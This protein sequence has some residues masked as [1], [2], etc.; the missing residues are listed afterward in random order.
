MLFPE[1]LHLFSQ[2]IRIRSGEILQTMDPELLEHLPSFGTDAAHLTQVSLRSSLGIAES[3]P[4]AEC[5]LAT[6]RRKG[7]WIVAIEIKTEFAQG[8]SQLLTQTSGHADT[9]SRRT[10]TPSTTTNHQRIPHRS[11]LLLLQQQRHQGKRQLV[12][13]GHAA[14]LTRQHRLIGKVAPA[15]A[16]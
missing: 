9:F 11:L 4:A 10:T 15:T 8:I 3:T 14:A 5:A 13:P 16:T 7:R 6:I 1:T 12:F 2:P